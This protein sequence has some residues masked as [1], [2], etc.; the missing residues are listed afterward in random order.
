M[1]M[2]KTPTQEK[3][4]AQRH[5]DIK[6]IVMGALEKYR[7][8]QKHLAALAAIEL[9]ISDAALYRWC[10]DLGINID[11]YRLPAQETAQ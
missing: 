3:L 4:E 11:D 8:Q 10:R 2:N 1:M 7:G 5:K 9:D 6:D